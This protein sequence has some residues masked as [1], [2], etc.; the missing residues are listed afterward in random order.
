[1]VKPKIVFI[2]WH[3]T[4][5]NYKFFWHLEKSD[6]KSQNELFKITTDSLFVKN[7]SL[8]LIPD[9]LR[10]KYTSE[11]IF[12]DL[13][14][15]ISVDFDIIFNEFVKSYKDMELISPNIPNLIKKLKRKGIKFYLATDNMDSFERW[16]VPELKLDKLFD[17]ILNS[18]NLKAL[19]MDVDEDGNSLFFKDILKKNGVIPSE[20]IL[21]DDSEDKDER[22][23]KYGI[24]YIRINEDNNLESNLLK[25]LSKGDNNCADCHED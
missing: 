6:N 19:K 13:S 5:C 24:N 16:V 17:G 8:C 15:N 18:Y 20:T 2:D 21:F 25:L 9:W 4:L 14:K 1:M 23:A 11:Q 10:G 3:N 22:L 7:T 12:K